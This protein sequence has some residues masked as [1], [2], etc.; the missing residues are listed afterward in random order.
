MIQFNVYSRPHC[1]ACKMTNNVLQSLHQNIN[2]V[3]LEDSNPKTASLIEKLKTQY[4]VRQ[5][6]FVQVVQNDQIK[7]TWSGFHPDKIKQWSK[8]QKEAI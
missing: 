6:P 3:V 2:H 1:M 5:M 8:L 4:H 7:D